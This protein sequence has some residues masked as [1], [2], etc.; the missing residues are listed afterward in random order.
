MISSKFLK[1]EDCDPP[2]LLTV[3]GVKQDN[4]GTEAEPDEKWT[5]LF[6]EDVGIALRH[7][8]VLVAWD[9]VWWPTCWWLGRRVG[10]LDDVLVAWDGPPV[11]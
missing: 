9:G 1:K 3:R 6:H 8:H 5:L 10:A 2:I 11:Y 4:V 7:A